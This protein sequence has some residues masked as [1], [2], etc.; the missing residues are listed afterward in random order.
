MSQFWYRI[1]GKETGR[2]QRRKEGA[3]QPL[4]HGSKVCHNHTKGH[5]VDS[6]YPW[7]GSCHPPQT[8]DELLGLMVGDYTP[9]DETIIITSEDDTIIIDKI[10]S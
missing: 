1:C 10:K 2:K 9:A 8:Q 6:Q 7:K 3:A 4:C 5:T